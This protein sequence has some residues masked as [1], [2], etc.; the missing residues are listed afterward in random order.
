MH[1][2]LSQTAEYALR[3]VA[4]IASESPQ[5]PVLSRELSAGT[6]IPAQYLSKILRRLVL[7]GILESRKGRG[8]GF[9]LIRPPG[10]ITFRDVLSAVDA[11]PDKDGCAFGWG[12]CDQRNP[13]PLHDAWSQ[14]SEGFRDWAATSNFADLRPLTASRPSRKRRARQKP[15]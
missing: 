3:A 5:K 15:R 7:A 14:M 1:T 11:Y 2:F 10:E 9:T 6:Q 4:W 13:C 8:G 12:S